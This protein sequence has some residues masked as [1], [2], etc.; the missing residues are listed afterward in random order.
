FALAALVPWTLFSQALIGSSNSLVNA[1]NMIQKVYFPRLILPIAALGSFLLDFGIAMLVLLVIMATAG[2][3]PTL[4]A[5]WVVP[6]AA[7]AV[8]SA[9]GLGIFLS[10]LNVR[11]RDTRVLI[12][13]LVQ[14]GLF[15]SPIVYSSDLVPDDWRTLYYLNPMATVIEGFRWALLGTTAPVLASWVT[16]TAVCI[17]VLISGLFYFRRVERTF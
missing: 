4:F 3:A 12:P 9:L 6:F 13:F 7:L 17:V 16:S 2:V 11:Y 15:A 1:S 10:A 5:I 14:L 8:A